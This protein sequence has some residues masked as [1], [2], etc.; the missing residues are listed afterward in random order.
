MPNQAKTRNLL[1]L[2]LLLSMLIASLM[3]VLGGGTASASIS[4]IT[5]DG[6]NS[7]GWTGDAYTKA[8]VGNPDEAFTFGK[9]EL[10]SHT[11][12]DTGADFAGSPIKFD[13]KFNHATDYLG[14]WWGRGV[15]VGSGIANGLYMGPAGNPDSTSTWMN[16]RIGL[17]PSM[18]GPCS[19]YCATVL[20]PTTIAW[21]VNRWYTV[22]VKISANS[23]SYFVDGQLIQSIATSLPVDNFVTFGG[24]DRNGYGFTDGVYLDN[25]EISPPPFRAVTYTASASTDLVPTQADAQEGSS[26]SVGSAVSRNLFDFVGWSDGNS[27]FQPGS[28][29]LVGS[30]NVTLTATWEPKTHQ[31]NFDPQ[32]GSPVAAS[33]FDNVNSFDEPASPV[34]AGYTFVGWALTQNGEPLSSSYVFTDTAPVTVFAKW[35]SDSVSLNF[36]SAGGSPVDPISYEI[37]T[38]ISS[39]PTDPTR[40][41]YVFDGWKIVANGPAVTFPYFPVLTEALSLAVTSASLTDLGD[42]YVNVGRWDSNTWYGPKRPENHPRDVV[43]YSNGLKYVAIRESKNTVIGVPPTPDG[44]YLL[45]LATSTTLIAS[46]SLESQTVTYDLDGGDGVAPTQV[47]VDSFSSFVIADPAT[48]S[49]FTF[50]GWSDGSREYQ[51]GETYQVGVLPVALTASWTTLTFTT[52]GNNNVTV[53]GCNGTCP[54]NLV[55]PS[56]LGGKSVTKIGY[57]AFAYAGLSSVVIP[58]SV[59][60]IGDYSFYLSQMQSVVI[61]DSVTTIGKNSFTMSGISTL[62]L[63]SSVTTI[64]DS[65]FAG[66]PITSLELP[67]SLVTIGASAFE[68]SPI[69]SLI[70][71]NSVVKIGAGAFTNCQITSLT[72]GS[73]LQRIGSFAFMQNQ[74]TTLTLPSSLKVIGAVAFSG[75]QLSSINFGSGLT[76][77][78]NSAFRD[79]DLD[80]LV[81]PSSVTAIGTRAFSENQL[82]SL[83]LPTSIT[84]ISNYAFDKNLLTTVTIP[85]TVTRIGAFA[86]S[87]NQITSLTVG[88]S[89]ETIGGHAFRN[90]QIRSVM[91]PSSLTTIGAYAFRANG[92]RSLTV[93][94]SVVTRGIRLH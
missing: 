60:A 49:G 72:L 30:S 7:S 41:G 75:N 12:G 27:L 34:R 73:S 54:A 63:G 94:E 6:S 10:M 4:S 83:T 31:L 18:A 39:A 32:G 70:I 88:N 2:G 29:Y 80:S 91:L 16:G 56:T 25:I 50:T 55:I 84:N 77:I 59:T 53:T 19:Y 33:T 44:Y 65:A 86:F 1:S 17:V 5:D 92:M 87:N 78:G 52:D 3:A 15:N 11:F 14:L 51:P 9:N 58:G 79:N 62:A 81:I 38:S 45:P 68:A 57:G 8:G 36:D 40:A 46:W 28:Q 89:V 48:R 21:D 61:P 37:G 85:N 64:G 74:L 76:T 26:F 67:G 35:S 93:P 42:A 71:P 20:E 66:N 69:T 90:N 24:D 43:S 47:A 23:T 13:I 22:E 82:T